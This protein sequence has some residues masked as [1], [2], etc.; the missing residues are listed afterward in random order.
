[1]KSSLLIVI[2]PLLALCGLFG[3]G[4]DVATSDSASG[5]STGDTSNVS[6]TGPTTGGGEDCEGC[7]LNLPDCQCEPPSTDECST[8]T[9]SVPDDIVV[10]PALPA[11]EPDSTPQ[12]QEAEIHSIVAPDGSEYVVT[13][14]I[15]W[16]ARDNAG[17]D[18][19]TH[20][21]LQKGIEVY[22]RETP[23]DDF[24]R[25]AIE[26]E[27]MAGVESYVVDLGA[28]T[29]LKWYTDP[30]LTVGPATGVVY[31]SLFK[32]PAVEVDQGQRSCTGDRVAV[33]NDFM[34]EIQV[35]AIRHNGVAITAKKVAVDEFGQSSVSLG[36]NGSHVGTQG[37]GALDRTHI[38]AHSVASDT[39][40]VV[41]IFKSEVEHPD[42]QAAPDRFVT[43]ACSW[44]GFD[45]GCV[46]DD[47]V[48]TPGLQPY[49]YTTDG[50]LWPNLNVDYLGNI[51]ISRIGQT[52]P[53]IH[54]YSW[55]D[56][57]KA[58]ALDHL[59]GPVPNHTPVSPLTSHMVTDQGHDVA[60]EVSPAIAVG[61]LGNASEPVVWVA[62]T[63]IN[64]TGDYG[65]EISAA[66]GNDLTQWVGPIKVPNNIDLNQRSN[67]FSQNLGVNGS[68]NFL[69]VVSYV[70]DASPNPGSF[71]LSYDGP[72]WVRVSRFRAHDLHLVGQKDIGIDDGLL[73][74]ELP[75][76]G[77]S[78]SNFG[79]FS[80]FLGEYFGISERPDGA[81]VV[82]WNRQVDGAGGF[83]R[84]DL[85]ATEVFSVCAS[86]ISVGNEG[87]DDPTLQVT[88]AAPGD[89][90]IDLSTFGESLSSLCRL[91]SLC[92]ES[93]GLDLGFTAVLVEE[94]G[95]RPPLGG[96]RVVGSGA[97]SVYD[98]EIVSSTELIDGLLGAGINVVRL[99]ATD[100]ISAVELGC[101]EQSVRV[102]GPL[103]SS[104][105][106][107][108]HFAGR[109][110]SDYVP[111]SGLAG[112]K[113]FDVGDDSIDRVSLPSSLGFTY[114]GN[115]V[116]VVYVSANGG[117]SFGLNSATAAPAINASLPSNS[118][119]D[120]SVY[121][122]D[123]DPSVQGDVLG[124]F[125]GMRY[126]VSWEDV[127]HVA[128]GEE[129][130]VQAHLY[131]GGRIE[132]HYFD[133]DVGSPGY[134][135][136]ASATIGIQ[137][138]GSDG[139]LLSHDS[140]AL[141]A[142]GDG[143]AIDTTA[144]IASPFVIPPSVA[145]T[146]PA[147]GVT[148]CTS[149]SAPVIIPQPDVSSCAPDAVSVEGRVTH[150]G[151]SR[152]QQYVRRQP[153]DIVDGWVQL[154]EGVHTVEWVARTAYGVRVSM[155]FT[156]TVFAAPWASAEN[157]CPEDQSMA[158][159]SESSDFAEGSNT[160]ECVFARG[161]AD[162][163]LGGGGDDRIISGYDDDTITAM[164]GDDMLICEAGDDFAFGGNGGDLIDGGPGD[165]AMA[166][167][168]D[169]DIID[170]GVGEDVLSGGEGADVLRGRGGDDVL[171][172]GN[173]SDH[174]YPGS[175]ADAVFAD[176]G[177]D[178]LFILDTCE[179]SVGKTLSGGDGQDTL[180]LP[181]GIT[182]SALEA[183]G[184]IVDEDI[185]IVLEMMDS[186][187]FASDCG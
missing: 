94:N 61:R 150:S 133:T 145:C 114:Y 15:D 56:V 135:N 173:G 90:R 58:W 37:L 178:H 134:D 2:S 21:I 48:K 185:E 174:L 168:G 158:V 16:E 127:R 63:S 79:P 13:Q 180:H 46:I 164:G 44:G 117:I 72:V 6:A 159:L 80:I 73:L 17:P 60:T 12:S 126:I 136:G 141:I 76:R 22:R 67:N 74:S 111:L 162:S 155:P 84:S 28:T 181:P 140:D 97:I 146:A 19:P 116:S 101:V 64:P 149:C 130:S 82:A 103:N 131:P 179:L 18:E 125:D 31:M 71:A 11:Q 148:L 52:Q 157:C 165:D 92:I 42:I 35:W 122:D 65:V 66:N 10:E 154:D 176:G 124:F 38:A 128:S 1:M 55:N 62:W 81:G 147:I 166:G 89:T 83:R 184:I 183:A 106:S 160:S 110:A 139:L 78:L 132:F 86:G 77:P 20:C 59:G 23:N 123:L 118:G 163:V 36:L 41:V 177:D 96:E 129:I 109:V 40:R 99:C 119:P 172:G 33:T 156:Q 186:Q 24:V 25:I 57:N 30:Y 161:G 34:E 39:D 115:S 27:S 120:L 88:C 144:C 175:G 138:G 68:L 137:N 152:D 5:S 102:E 170:G 167:E 47:L 4:D 98:A 143:I 113:T 107:Y 187:S 108:G 43:L 151:M 75:A 142:G 87:S 112:V 171:L 32:A 50:T 54:K 69:D 29:S 7:A 8:G 169:N 53:I 100:A 91:T 95:Q 182:I 9:G 85:Y 45:D 51:Y 49:P 14:V 153:L 93:R 26:D 121:W 70:A 3:C 104:L 105:D